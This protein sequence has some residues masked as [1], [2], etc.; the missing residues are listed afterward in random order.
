MHPFSAADIQAAY[1]ETGMTDLEL[2]T[3]LLG[4]KKARELDDEIGGNIGQLFQR[5]LTGIKTRLSTTQRHRVMSALMLARRLNIRMTMSNPALTGP[6]HATQIAKSLL[7][8]REREM[9]LVVFL[10]NSHRV[11]SHTIMFMGA[12]AEVQMCPREISKAALFNNA[13]AVILAH[14]HPSNSLEPSTADIQVTTKI[15]TALDTVGVRLLDHIIVTNVGE[16]SL[17]NRGLI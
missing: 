3:L 11:I 1:S 14:N 5:G 4:V 13:V 7:K 8:Y 2:L 15:R 17:A 12:V 16:T 6:Q 9:G 10:D